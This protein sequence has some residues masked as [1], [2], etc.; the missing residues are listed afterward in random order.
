MKIKLWGV[1][2]SMPTPV[3]GAIIER[4]IRRVLQ[5]ARPGDVSS[6]EAIES[7]LYSL[8][9]SLTSTYGGNTSCIEVVTDSGELIIL[10]CGSGIIGLGKELMKGE[11]GK[12][13]GAA[14]ILISHTHWDHIHGIPFFVPAFVPGNRFTFYSPME[15]LHERLKYQQEPTHFPIRL[16]EMMA[17]K[18]FIQLKEDEEFFLNNIRVFV[19]RMPHPGK[20]FAYRIEDGGKVC[21]YTSDCEFN[22]AEIEE[23]DSYYE[24]FHDADVIIFDAQYTLEEALNKLDWGHSSGYIALDVAARFR[25]KQLILFHHEPN[26]D[27]EK[28]DN[29]LSNTLSYQTMH[30]A[31]VGSVKVDIAREGLEI[32]L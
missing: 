31:A 17:T 16:D 10:D 25:A 12:G 30:E 13:K 3:S 9:F 18:D 6:E 23:I 5:L 22:I 8:P 11:F 29:I 14:S 27:D 4:K 1:R 20:S 21:V 19:K 7:F 24:L 2:G 28:L 32:I 15:N 26:Y